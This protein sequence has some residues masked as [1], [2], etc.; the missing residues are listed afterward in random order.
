MVAEQQPAH[1]DRAFRGADQVR[2]NWSAI[3]DSV[4]D[5]RSELV[6]ADAA[7]RLSAH[8]SRRHRLERSVPWPVR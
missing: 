5:F 1:P 3:F 6:R 2:E 4:K 8:I 7:G